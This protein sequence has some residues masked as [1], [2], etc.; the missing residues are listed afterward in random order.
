MPLYVCAQLFSFSF[1]QTYAWI[2]L[3][4]LEELFLAADK[5]TMYQNL[6]CKP[7]MD[8]MELLSLDKSNV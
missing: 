1:I 6:Q 3:S 7:H 8:Q 2:M 5:Y 4:V